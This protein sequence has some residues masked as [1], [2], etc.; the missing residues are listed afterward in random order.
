M[1]STEMK[2]R[3]DKLGAEPFV[4]ASAVFNK[5]IVDETAKS[6]QIVH[7]AGMIDEC[8]DQRVDHLG[9]VASGELRLID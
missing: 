8:C 5:F 9:G 1:T 4:L 7:A 6:Q 3:L 2:E